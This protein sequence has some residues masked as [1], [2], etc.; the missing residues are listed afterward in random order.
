M[1]QHN[2]R[3]HEWRLHVAQMELQHVV[4][5]ISR[6]SG[7]G[8]G[9][10]PPRVGKPCAGKQ[11]ISGPRGVAERGTKSSHHHH[12]HACLF[13]RRRLYLPSLASKSATV[14]LTPALVG[15]VMAV[16]AYLRADCCSHKHD[17]TAAGADE[18]TRN[19]AKDH[20]RTHTLA[21]QLLPD[22]CAGVRTACSCSPPCMHRHLHMLLQGHEK[23]RR[24]QSSRRPTSARQGNPHTTQARQEHAHAHNATHTTRRTRTATSPYVQ[25]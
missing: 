19:G 17:N 18:T 24:T 14:G 10:V 12:H 1:S 6:Q 15:L 8:S 23:L 22:H 9:H 7:N 25:P 21:R 5:V 3:S 13:L 11:N 4:I 20:Q 16:M 2:E